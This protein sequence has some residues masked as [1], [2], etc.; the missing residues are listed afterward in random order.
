MTVPLTIT[1]LREPEHPGALL[2]VGP[3]LGTAVTPLWSS[4]VQ[5]L[6]ADVA[7]IGWDLPGHGDG[8]AYDEPFS[9]A[10][11]AASVMA[12]T[13][14]ARDE[15]TG[16][17]VYA[18]VSIGGQVG[19]ELAIEHAESL[20]G[21]VVVCSGAKIG[22]ADAWRER[23]G[24]V[25]GAGTPVLVE[26]STQRWFA[27]ATIDRDPALVTTLLAALAGADRFSYA[28]CCEALA[29]FDARDRLADIQVPVLALAGEHDEVAP[30]SLARAI[31]DG[32]GGRAQHVVGAG[33]LAPAEQP[34]AVAG[35]LV[36]FLKGPVAESAR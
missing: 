4:C 8:A 29:G 30:L 11:L 33:H 16:L 23:A 2:I 18:G 36:E 32:T 24:L 19:L 12:A 35:L 26:A 9:I 20:D 13:E 17:V 10:E 6:P 3:S 7:V 14:P 27:P 21:V 31:A 28:R 1:A 25:R 34:A 22:E 15:A 5:H